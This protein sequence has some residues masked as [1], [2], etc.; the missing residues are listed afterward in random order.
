M[1][2]IRPVVTPPGVMRGVLKTRLHVV[3]HEVIGE[4]LAIL[5]LPQQ[6]S[7]TVIGKDIM[8]DERIV[9]GAMKQ[10]AVT[11]VVRNHISLY[12]RLHAGLKFDAV[13]TVA[14]NNV[15]KNMIAVNPGRENAD[16]AID[17]RIAFDRVPGRTKT[18]VEV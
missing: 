18:T 3:V 9:A 14:R 8:S 5:R 15:L 16:A 13:Q 17:N 12:R 11:T 4:N 1:R 10:D 6:E 7:I 2:P